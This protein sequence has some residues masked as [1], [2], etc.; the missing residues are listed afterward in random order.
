MD[1]QL[2]NEQQLLSDSIG[3]MLASTYDF[4]ERLRIV[5]SEAGW[6]R[7][8]WQAFGELGLLAAPMSTA[9][10]GF[11][12]GSV[13]TQIIMEALGR[14]VVVEPFLETVVVAGG[15]IE[16]LGS[17]DQHSTWLPGIMS[18]DSILVPAFYESTSRY[19]L[20]LVATT[21]TWNGENYVLQGA[22]SIV[23]GAPWADKF[24]VSARTSTGATGH[25]ISLFVVDRR[26]AGL[27]LR[28]FRTID[29]R[30]AAELTFDGVQVS[31][32]DLLG[33]EGRAIGA[34]E[35]IRD[36]AIA[37]LCAEAVGG[38]EVLL[39]ATTEFS[40]TRRQ[41]GVALG[42]FQ[43]L[44]HRMVDMFI[45]LEEARSLTN[46]LTLALASG[47]KADRKLAAATKAKV[48]D[49]AR[50]VGEQA[51]QIHGGMG[52][53]DELNVGHYLKRLLAI[54]IAFGDPAF[55]IGRYVSLS[56]G[57]RGQSSPKTGSGAREV[58]PAAV[59]EGVKG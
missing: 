27:H 21:A 18:G 7:E 48:G 53:S 28:D 5:A 40:K 41:F 26:A 20:D 57:S 23:I 19:R 55:H 16:R 17:D 49:A 35:D 33:G 31:A 37:A 45:A 10:G 47:A 44:Q 1:I 30:R 39:K 46:A 11:G 24:I 32:A 59:Q 58:V 8:V 9:V 50:Y 38:M 13:A 29:G 12:G 2:D 14:H 22:K 25:G 42:T 52:M 43:V 54:N 4:D 56:S 34:L 15:L 6:S 51:V 36:H 3:K